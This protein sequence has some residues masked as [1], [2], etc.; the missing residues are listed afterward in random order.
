MTPIIPATHSCADGSCG[1]CVCCNSLVQLAESNKYNSQLVCTIA[2]IQPGV[3]ALFQHAKLLII[4]EWSDILSYYRSRPTY[5]PTPRPPRT[6]AAT[7]SR[8]KISADEKRAN[9]AA[10]LAK[11]KGLK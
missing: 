9:T 4:G 11:L 7:K 5:I 2:E 3:F 1:R 6:L 8:G 10:L